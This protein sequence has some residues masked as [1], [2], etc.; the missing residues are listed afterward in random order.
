MHGREA[1]HEYWTRQWSEIDPT[2]QPV[3]F[4]TRA[5][6]SVAVDVEQ[7]VRSLDGEVIG[8]GRVVHVYT[9]EG[10]LVASCVDSRA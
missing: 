6:G 10:D 2:V 5:D 9:F 3:A 4:T 1:V 7:Q 8:E